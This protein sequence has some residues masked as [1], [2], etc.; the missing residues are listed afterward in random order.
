MR[1]LRFL[2]IST[3]P[4]TTLGADDFLEFGMDIKELHIVQSNLQT[5]K[6]HA[7]QHVR[8]IKYLDFS[9]NSISS[10]ENDAF[11]EVNVTFSHVLISKVT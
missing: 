4:G 3:M 6:N 1:N 2:S 8:G 7:F 11:T 10:I 9:E 5:I